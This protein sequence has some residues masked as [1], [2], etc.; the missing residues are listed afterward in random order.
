MR[1]HRVRKTVD[2]V[3]R[4]RAFRRHVRV[5]RPARL[6]AANG[7]RL[8]G[9]AEAARLAGGDRVARPAAAGHDRGTLHQR[10]VARRG[11]HEPRTDPRPRERRGIAP[12]RRRRSVHHQRADVL[13]RGPDPRFRRRSAA[14]LSSA[15]EGR[16]PCERINRSAPPHRRELVEHRPLQRLRARGRGARVSREHTS[17]R[18]RPGVQDWRE[19][20][21]FLERIRV[22]APHH[23]APRKVDRLQPLHAE[24]G[25]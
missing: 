2:R 6:R 20:H 7:D 1:E 14:G 11:G 15:R 3:S 13:R 5:P 10:L 23:A 8:S 4:P 19:R 16:A 17:A 25:S 18:S 22:C 12:R 24:R 21:L 9:P